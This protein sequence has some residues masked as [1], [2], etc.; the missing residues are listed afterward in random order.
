MM[1]IYEYICR[2]CNERFTVIQSRY[3]PESDIEC[4]ECI[5]REVEKIVAARTAWAGSEEGLSCSACLTDGNKD[6]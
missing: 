5:S 1:A 6:S 3:A 4:P 2:K